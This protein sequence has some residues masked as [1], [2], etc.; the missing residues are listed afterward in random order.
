MKPNIR[1]YKDLG[2][3]QTLLLKACPPDS[4]GKKSIPLLAQALDVSHQYVYRWIEENSV[5][6]KYVSKI[7]GLVDA[8]APDED[9][10]SLEDFHAYV[11]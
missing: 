6:P 3:L 2:A 10:V 5:P 1:R 9:K 11:F 4:S 8:A 7:V